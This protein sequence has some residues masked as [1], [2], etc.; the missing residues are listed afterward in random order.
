[1]PFLHL[2][3]FFFWLPFARF[4]MKTFEI[5]VRV[6]RSGKLYIRECMKSILTPNISHN[7]SHRLVGFLL[8]WLR[9][10][11][12]LPL[13]VL[14]S[15]RRHRRYIHYTL[16]K[17]FQCRLQINITLPFEIS[18]TAQLSRT[19]LAFDTFIY[20]LLHRTEMNY[21]LL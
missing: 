16:F 12:S 4:N 14:L 20:N 10:S 8:R 2:P 3:S 19:I 6:R 18:T 11:L 17:I 1:M 13:S 15:V 9:L 21:S 5:F 7:F